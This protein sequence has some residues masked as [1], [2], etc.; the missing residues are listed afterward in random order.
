ML[1]SWLAAE[2][3]LVDGILGGLFGTIT[4]FV[5]Q[6]WISWPHSIPLCRLGGAIPNLKVPAMDSGV[7]NVMGE[8]I[9]YIVVNIVKGVIV[10]QSVLVD[11][12]DG[13][14]E[15]NVVLFMPLVL[16][17]FLCYPPLPRII[18]PLLRQLRMP[19]FLPVKPVGV[20]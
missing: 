19:L 9:P 11:T 15:H 16:Y 6:L 17:F 5:P 2:P 10:A 8:V 13:N 12:T 1:L 3:Y 20:T 7:V 4:S 18:R 14:I